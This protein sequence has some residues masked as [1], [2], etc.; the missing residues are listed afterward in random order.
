MSNCEK[1]T[2]QKNQCLAKYSAIQSKE[3]CCVLELK[4][5]KCLAFHHCPT[6]A[7]TY[8]S[9]APKYA[10]YDKS[11]CAA[12][13]ET[14]CFGNP[15]VMKIDHDDAQQVASSEDIFNY[16]LKAKRKMIDNRQRYREC[17]ILSERL[18]RCLKKAT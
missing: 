7:H 16:H 6:E 3:K 9:G 10:P 18:N 13:E 4:E 17:Q 5:K 1:Y 12:F 8:Y 11:L 14:S 2:V 15:R